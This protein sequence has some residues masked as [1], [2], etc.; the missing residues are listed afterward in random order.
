M[1]SDWE[2]IRTGMAGAEDSTRLASA[3][4]LEQALK[5]ELDAGR[6]D[7]A[8]LA[9][10]LLPALIAGIGDAHKGVQ[11]HSANCLQFLAYQSEAIIPALREA[12]AGP[13][14]WRAWGAAIVFARMGLWSP[15]VGPALSAAMGARDR[16]VRWAAAGYALTLGRSHPE[17]VDMVKQTLASGEPVARKMA[18]Y[19][20]G[21]MGAYAEVEADLAARLSDPERDVRRAVI[22]AIDKLPTSSEEVR[23]QIAALR[24][25][26][27]P[28][29]QRTADAVAKKF[30]L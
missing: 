6:R 20:L 3:Y 11:V 22:L 29:I 10:Q 8:D 28:F 23:Q 7:W 21:A 17:A 9:D 13:D 18:A 27:D 2:R 1:A 16:D 19:C 24:S 5:V 4:A 12:M 26:P 25:D 30:G 15:E 14:T